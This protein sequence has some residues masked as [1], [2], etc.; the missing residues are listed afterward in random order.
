MTLKINLSMA[1]MAIAALA[2]AQDRMVKGSVVSDLGT[3]V[4]HVQVCVVGA[5][6]CTQTDEQGKFEISASEGDVLLFANQ[7]FASQE[8]IVD[9]NDFYN[10][11]L[12]VEDIFALDLSDLMNT[13]IESSSFLELKAKEAPGYVFS[14]D[15]PGRQ[16]QQ[17]LIDIMR[18]IVPAYSDGSHPDNEIFGVRGMKV[19]DNSKSIVMFDGQNLNMRSNIGYGICLQSNL[20]GDVK[21]VEVALGPN[22]IVHGSGAISGYVNMLPK[23]GY[24]NSGFR[25]GVTKEFLPDANNQG[26]GINKAEFSYGFGTQKRNAFFYAGWYHSNGWEADSAFACNYINSDTLALH[27][28]GATPKANFRLSAIANFDD[29]AL[30]VAYMQNSR[31]AFNKGVYQE[32]VQRQ[33]NGKLKWAHNFNETE[34]LTLSLS[35]ELTD[36][37]RIKSGV[38]GGSEGHVEGKLVATTKRIPNNQLAIGGMFGARKFHAADFFFGSDIDPTAATS[39][40]SYAMSNETGKEIKEPDSLLASAQVPEGEWKEWAV[41]LEDVYKLNDVL[42]FALGLRADF[43]NIDK[44]ADNQHSLSPRVGVSWLI[45]S[46]HVLK[47]TYQQGFRTADYYNLIQTLERKNP[48]VQATFKKSE[49]GAEFANFE[50]DFEPEKLHS[51]ELNYHGDFANSVISLDANV[52]FNRYKKNIDIQNLVTW[53]GRKTAEYKG[54]D[55]IEV[56]GEYYGDFTKTAEAY[57]TLEQRREF[58]LNYF[59]STSYRKKGK[60]GNF[61]IY[62]NSGEDI[63]IYGGELIANLTLPCGT[64][65]KAAYSLAISS[66]DD[67]KAKTLHPEHSIKLDVRQSLFSGKVY[68]GAQ[69]LWEPALKDN[70][71]NRQNYHE[72][73]F[74]SRNVLDASISYK[75][76]APLSIFFDACNIL[77]QNRPHITFK[78]SQSDNYLENTCLG[79]GERKFRLGICVNL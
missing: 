49:A 30:N 24:D 36:L 43:Y 50:F 56:E 60:I 7:G 21:A 29:F 59:S 25:I 3:V 77:G 40:P 61:Q 69:Y 4:S 35:S 9:N 5:N 45:N 55:K 65:A 64:Q 26:S 31:V 13:K 39:E 79:V 14:Y 34:A 20:L 10:V 18:M 70:E 32:G 62:A 72:V 1:L 12:V 37:A 71:E 6:R 28:V 46:N 52:F 58:A 22:A 27:P 66:N 73:Y 76:I 38:A 19:V 53:D 75:P 15:S 11:S 2:N 74:D 54:E 51:F 48:Q 78:P 63:D 42:V 67:Y 68:I 16:A 44:I 33:L 23:N 41:F 8:V 57:M 17:S 47:A